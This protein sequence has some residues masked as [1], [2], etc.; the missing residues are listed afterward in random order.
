V[1]DFD[2]AFGTRFSEE[3]CQTV[4]GLILHHL[5]RVPQFNETIVIDGICFQVLRADSRRIYTLVVSNSPEAGDP[6]E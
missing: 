1:A 4:G 3:K 2:A 6:A 5:G